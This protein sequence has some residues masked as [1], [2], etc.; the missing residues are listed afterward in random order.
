MRV[1]HRDMVGFR[2]E[3]SEPKV[4]LRGGKWSYK[5]LPLLALGD[6]ISGHKAPFVVPYIP[7]YGT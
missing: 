5:V 6:L 1:T 2:A 7:E 3:D 4:F